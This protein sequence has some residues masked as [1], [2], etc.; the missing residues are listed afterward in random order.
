MGI[1]FSKNPSSPCNRTNPEVLPFAN[2]N[3]LSVESHE[4]NSDGT[5]SSID[6]NSLKSDDSLILSD[7][8]EKSNSDE[9]L[10]EHLPELAEEIIQQE[11]IQLV[12]EETSEPVEPV[13]KVV[14]E[15]V[16]EEPVVEETTDPVEA[17]E[18]I[19]VEETVV[20]EKQEEINTEKV[21]EVTPAEPV[22]DENVEE[23]TREHKED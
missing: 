7:S 3:N 11:N 21:N 18:N 19:V 6:L 16:V 8:G 13:E 2:D 1:L 4:N 10:P 9:S 20:E 22:I 12:V 15:Q 23:D 17:V 5:L 14:E